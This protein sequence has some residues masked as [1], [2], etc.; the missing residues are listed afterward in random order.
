MFKSIV[1][2]SRDHYYIS[3]HNLKIRRGHEFEDAFEGL[4]GKN[5]KD[6][7]KV[8]FINRYGFE[9]SGFDAGGLTKEL[10]TRVFR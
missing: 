1:Q 10:L 3:Q 2:D 9:E 6:K 8:V 4:K 7:Y 5:I